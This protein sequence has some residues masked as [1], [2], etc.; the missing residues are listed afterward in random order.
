MIHTD[1]SLNDGE[2]KEIMIGQGDSEIEWI[3]EDCCRNMKAEEISQV[4]L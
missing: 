4:A 3:I 1:E 2:R